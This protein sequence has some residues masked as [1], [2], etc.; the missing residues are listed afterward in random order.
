MNEPIKEQ[1]SSAKLNKSVETDNETTKNNL[2]K[3]KIFELSSD[4][5]SNCISQEDSLIYANDYFNIK[6]EYTEIRKQIQQIENG[7][8]EFIE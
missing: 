6:E 1:N 2:N 8:N 3:N 7:I 5:N 4:N